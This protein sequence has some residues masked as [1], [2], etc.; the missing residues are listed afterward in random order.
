MT[1]ANA[2][3]VAADTAHHTGMSERFSTA[4]TGCEV[5]ENYTVENYSIPLVHYYLPTQR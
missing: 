5:V 1:G 4:T 3:V 2:T